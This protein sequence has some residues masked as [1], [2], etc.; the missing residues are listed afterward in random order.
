MYQQLGRIG[1][2]AILA[3]ILVASAIA[4]NLP[5]LQA[6]TSAPS[7]AV[8]PTTE[9]AVSEPSDS[10]QE[11]LEPT[12][13]QSTAPT[14]PAEQATA[15]TQP[16]S[17]ATAEPQPAEPEPP[18]SDALNPNPPATPV[19]LIFI[20]HSTGGNWL[21]SPSESDRG[22]G[23]GQALMENNYFVSATNYGWGPD[24][25][26]DRT[27]I[28]NW[29]EWFLDANR[30]EIMQAVYDET[31]QNVGDFGDWPRLDDDPGGENEIILFKSCYPNS[32]LF[33]NPDDGPAAEISYDYTVANA[34]AIY[35]E[36][37]NYFGMAQD[38]L[39]VV[40]TAPP[41]ASGEYGEDPYGTPEQ[42]AANARAFNDWLV[43]DWLADY[44]YA[45][46]AV[47][48][49]YNVLTSNGSAARVDD[50]NTMDE[51]ADT[52]FADGNHHRWSGSEIEHLQT[53]DF[54]Y[55]AYPSDSNWDSHPAGQ[56]HQK[57]T[58]EFIPLL[59]I[60]YHR[61]QEAR[62]AVGS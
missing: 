23:L 58:T 9:P 35:I 20:H 37:L 3:A 42:R 2:A 52:G 8:S 48:D 40:I 25:I 54:N 39:F 14:A 56:G 5:P 36:I 57:A 1:F 32:N 27:D 26:G 18:L 21:A 10:A 55:S 11:P 41:L 33:G 6:P 51:P 30:D 44:P 22:G 61:W 38:K 60:Y 31:G 17:L 16:D 45:N 15:T 50:P 29:P 7:E 46:V 12:V 53:V 19:K 47:F 34:K 28:V 24:S 59:N 62:Q 43:N 49:Y 4:C 13:S